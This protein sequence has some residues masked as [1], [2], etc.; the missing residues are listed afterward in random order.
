MAPLGQEITILHP[1]LDGQSSLSICS[2]SWIRTGPLIT[3]RARSP[4]LLPL[5]PLSLSFSIFLRRLVHFF[6]G[7][8]SGKQPSASRLTVDDPPPLSPG[9]GGPLNEVSREGVL[10]VEEQRDELLLVSWSSV[11]PPAAAVIGAVPPP[12]SLRLL[13]CP[14]W[15]SLSVLLE[16]WMEHTSW[17]SPSSHRDTSTAESRRRHRRARLS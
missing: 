11:V 9:D 4:L 13:C 6:L 3:Y 15:P 5:V 12:A 10:F 7:G 17:R 8:L 2:S 14:S 1:H 16:L